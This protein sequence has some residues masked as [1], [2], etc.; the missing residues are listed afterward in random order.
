MN[1]KFT[2]R[3]QEFFNH[4][5]EACIE[6]GDLV[7]LTCLKR[8]SNVQNL[9]WLKLEIFIVFN[10]LYFWMKWFKET[11][12]P[13][14]AKRL[15]HCWDRQWWVRERRQDGGENISVWFLPGEIPQQVSL[16][17]TWENTQRPWTN[18]LHLWE[19]ILRQILIKIPLANTRNRFTNKV[20][21]LREK[22]YKAEQ[23]TISH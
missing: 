7:C 1:C 6:K 19:E 23:I 8:F 11:F 16:P 14:S 17:D 13:S 5:D 12:T 9:R 20:W 18:L 22:L 21:T 15:Q 3:V 2:G 4:F 10:M